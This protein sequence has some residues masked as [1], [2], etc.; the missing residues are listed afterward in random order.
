MLAIP[1]PF[2][3]SLLLFITGVVLRCRYPQ[4]SQKPFWFIMLCVLMMMVV[5]LRWTLDIALVRFLQPVF[6]ASV[7][8]AAWLC[9]AGAHR[10][11]SNT[12]L[13]WL[14]PFAVLVSSF[15]YHHIWAGAVDVLL[16]LLYLGY[17]SLLLKSSFSV[18]ENVRLTDLSKV[19]VAER[20]AGGLLLFSALVDGVLSYDI[21]L[22]NAQYTSLILS[23]GYLVLIPAIVATVVV[24][25]LSTTSAS[26]Y[27]QPQVEPSMLYGSP[28]QADMPANSVKALDEDK[29]EETAQIMARFDVLMREQQVFKD[30]DLSLNRLA[31]KLGIPARKISAAVNQTHKQ[32]ISKVINA[33][34]IEHAKTLLKQSDEAIT[35]IFLSSGFQT[36]SNFNREFSRITGQ[37]PSEYRSSPQGLD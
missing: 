7:P 27:K 34:R 13:H 5:G 18:P 20:A 29:A 11:I 37:T 25:S 30:A 1:L 31:R 32:N 8:V 36:K 15:F 16:I 23:V 14:G 28:E 4:T 33:Y 6:S 26:E 19:V 2:V 21:L 17:G 22:L 24:V 9:F 12:Q 10:S 35:D 3:A